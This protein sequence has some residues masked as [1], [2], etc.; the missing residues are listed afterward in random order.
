MLEKKELTFV[1][2]ILYALGE[3]WNMTTTEVYEILNTTGILDDYIIKC[4][5][6][7]KTKESAKTDSLNQGK[8]LSK[9]G[10]PVSFLVEKTDYNNGLLFF[11]N[12]IKGKV[13]I[14][15]Y[16]TNFPTG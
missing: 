8:S 13:I 15:Y 3:H 7:K 9:N 2:F 14:D 11:I 16:K 1:V 6:V 5:E 12:S 4:Y 10:I